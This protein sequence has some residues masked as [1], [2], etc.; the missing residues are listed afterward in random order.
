VRASPFLPGLAH[1][2][3]LLTV[4]PPLL[5]VHPLC[6]PTRNGPDLLPWLAQVKTGG[7]RFVRATQTASVALLK[8]GAVRSWG[9]YASWP[10][11][12]VPDQLIQAGAA[13][14]LEASG[15]M[16]AARLAS[17]RSWLVW[18]PL[19]RYEEVT[20]LIM[21]LPAS[22]Q[23][24]AAGLGN[25]GLLVQDSV[26]KRLVARTLQMR[27]PWALQEPAPG[28]EVLDTCSGGVSFAAAL[29]ADKRVT[30]GGWV[31]ISTLLLSTVQL[32]PVLSGRGG[33]TIAL[34]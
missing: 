29:T 5:P 33:G 30:V 24:V 26:S 7:V 2:I 25:D 14:G 1:N 15:N 19:R 32:W 34:Q 8:S 9:C 13:T 10:P 11:C 22:I 28:K 17:D 23:S 21:K 16:A 3:A 12:L 4:T 6:S 31:E 18:Q 27:L 20:P